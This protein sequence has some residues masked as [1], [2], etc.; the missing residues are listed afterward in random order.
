MLKFS[1]KFVPM[2][3]I[4]NIP[5]LTQ[6]MACCLVGA[7][8]DPVHWL[9]YQALGGNEWNSLGPGDAIWRCRPGSI[10]GQIMACCLMAP[11]HYLNH[12]WL[13]DTKVQWHSSDSSFRRDAPA[14]DH[15]NL[16]QNYL[17]KI[18]SKSPRGQWFKIIV[19]RQHLYVMFTFLTRIFYRG[20]PGFAT[21]CPW[22]V[23]CRGLTTCPLY[24]G[25]L[26]GNLV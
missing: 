12:C 9:I 11:S 20:V 23:W 22:G 24:V 6:I 13:I 10:L 16:F 7:N 3:R 18:S 8:A 21:D 14:I 17:Y 26:F 25:P 15:W 19:V 1:L 2:V 4:N 5:T